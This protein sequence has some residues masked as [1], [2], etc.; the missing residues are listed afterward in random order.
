MSTNNFFKS[1]LFKINNIVQTSMILYPKELIIA[2]LRD[3]FSQDSY[4]HYVKDEFG[5]ANTTD[6]TDLPLD[7]GL[8]NNVTTRLFIGENYRNDLIFY[9]AILVK[10]AG[11]KYVPISINREEGAVQWEV[12]EFDDGYGNI[13]LYKAPKSLLFQGAWE[14]SI[15]IEILSRSLRARDELVEL[16]SILLTDIYFKT[17]Q[18]AG[19]IVKPISVGSPSETDDRND[20]LFRQTIT[21]EIRTEWRREIPVSNIL[22]V[23]NFS[24]DFSDISNNGPKAPNIQIN[25]YTG[26]VDVIMNSLFE[27]K[28]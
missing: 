22:E 19:V 26:L 7:A 11:A 23:I 2:A 9:P 6:H 13:T 17:L 21:L 18:K 12:R 16:V 27:V 28:P 24:M 5:F 1:D 20:K 25:T 4:Y 15:N 8:H 14:G 10:N 3:A